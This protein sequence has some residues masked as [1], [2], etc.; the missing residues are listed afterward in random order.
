MECE[1]SDNIIQHTA[2]NMKSCNA[3]FAASIGLKLRDIGDMRY[4]VN[5]RLL[6]LAGQVLR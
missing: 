4:C 5:A 3:A 1:R 6:S 2:T